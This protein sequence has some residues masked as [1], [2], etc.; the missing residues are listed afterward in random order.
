MSGHRTWTKRCACIAL[1]LGL[2]WQLAVTA[3]AMPAQ[4]MIIRHA[5]K[6]EDRNNIHLNPR[7]LTR[8]KALSQFFQSDPRVLEYGLP[9]AIIAQRPS[10]LKKSVRCEETVEP[11]AHAL[12]QPIINR[13]AYG[14]VAALA[15]WLRVSRE[16][17]NKSVLICAQHMDVVDIAKALGVPQVRQRVWPHETY[18]RV[19]LIDFSRADGSV[20]S[21][22]DI[23][24]KLLFGDSFQ[25]ASVSQEPGT[26]SFSQTY[27]ETTDETH[28][29]RRPAAIW[30]CCVVAEVPGDFSRFDDQTIPV[31]RL[32]G[33]TFGYYATTLGNLRKSKNALVTIDPSGQSGSFRFNYNALVDGLDKTYAWITFSW[34][35]ERLKA[36]FQAE[37]DETVIVPDLNMP[38]ECR[39]ARTEGT[40]AGVISCYLAFGEQRFFAPAG[41]AYRGTAKTSEDEANRQVYQVSLTEENGCI[42]R[43]LTPPE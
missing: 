39:L 24:Q 11:L 23:P 33:F 31:L 17:D 19:W 34:D 21:F 36:E 15:E 20:V 5:E 30:N 2:F 10:S 42:V 13:F 8:A 6:F 41:T 35:K 3:Q 37:I 22:R 7:G 38:V 14:E 28:P 25:E 43:N 4:V 16:W 9:A 26:V 27:R 29:E 12:G 32:G 1:F 40:M 18:D